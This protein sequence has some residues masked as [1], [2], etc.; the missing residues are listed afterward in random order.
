M[1]RTFSLMTVLLSL[2][3]L[4]GCGSGTSSSPEIEAHRARYLLSAAPAGP[5]KVEA[6]RTVV[7]G[8]HDHDHDHEHGDHDH[9]HAP[10]NVTVI[11]HIGGV[12][13]PW[14]R[15][16]AAF[17][18]SDTTAGHSHSH[19]HDHDHD[20]DHAHGHDHDHDHD[21]AHDH[22][23]D[24]SHEDG[25]NCPFCERA[26]PGTKSLAIVQFVDEKGEVLPIDARELFNLKEKQTVVVQG[27][28]MIDALGNLVISATG[29][30]VQ[31]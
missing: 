18:I 28:A 27:L 31:Q 6:A 26:K 2:V 7:Q 11:G 3:G 24:H 13:D 8:D 16:R 17:M 21:H 9:H 19:D 5:V 12:S 1:L 4:V 23:H 25:H 15:G 10:Q 29:I 20:H 22:A 14:D 30:F